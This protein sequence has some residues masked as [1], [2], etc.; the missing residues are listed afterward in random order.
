MVTFFE[1]ITTNEN[2]LYGLILGIGGTIIGL[3]L[4]F[5]R[6]TDDLRTKQVTLL[7]Q[8]ADKL[9][10]LYCEIASIEKNC[11]GKTSRKCARFARDY[12]NVINEI[13]YLKSNRFLGKNFITYFKYSFGFSIHLKSWM[14][15]T[16]ME[17]DD[18]KQ[19]YEYFEEW[20]KKI[21]ILNIPYEDLPDP[22][23][24]L[25]GHNLTKDEKEKRGLPVQIY[26]NFSFNDKNDQESG[27]TKNIH[28]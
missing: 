11:D 7:N 13:A 1:F 22:L 19:H 28:E 21:K 24:H 2:I 23:L 14:L 10:N 5:W 9:T 26:N 6:L 25:V 15:T 27:S 8:F 3:F 17:E 18:F 12:M 4:N 20:I 16:G